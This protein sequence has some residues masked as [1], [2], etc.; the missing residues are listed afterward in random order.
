ML[1]RGI[2]EIDDLGELDVDDENENENEETDEE[3]SG[4]ES[5]EELRSELQAAQ[6][7][8]QMKNS[9]TQLV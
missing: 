2:Q 8:I 5:L 9:T 6:A 4:T 3:N 1:V 7:E